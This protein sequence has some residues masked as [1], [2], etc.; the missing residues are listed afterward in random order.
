MGRAPSF[1]EGDAGSNPARSAT[2]RWAK[3]NMFPRLI[4]G[5]TLVKCWGQ[6]GFRRTDTQRQA[7]LVTESLRTEDWSRQ[8]LALVAQGK[9]HWFPKPRVVGS[10]PTWGTHEEDQVSQPGA[11]AAIGK[12]PTQQNLDFF[13]GVFAVIGWNKPYT[14]NEMI[15]IIDAYTA[16]PAHGIDPN[17]RDWMRSN[18]VHI[19]IDHADMLYAYYGVKA[20]FN[21]AV[22][23]HTVTYAPAK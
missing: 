8:A 12:F 13:N 14:H 16:D 3:P 15:D 4:L 7:C 21:M 5:R 20:T 2:C 11:S 19:S 9:E 22:N 10:I 23:P 17:D 6:A 1:L 18:F